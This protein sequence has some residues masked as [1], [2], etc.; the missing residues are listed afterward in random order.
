M[1]SLQTPQMG[2]ASVVSLWRYPVKSM[3]GEE[4]NA[5]AITSQGLLGDRAYALVDSSNGKVASAKN[6]RKWPYL[7][8]FRAA[9]VDPRALVRLCRRSGSPCRMAPWSAVSNPISTRSSPR[10]STVRSA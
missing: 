3:L 10:C 4:L 2:H 6:P 8:D 9:F 1:S 5:S 7:F